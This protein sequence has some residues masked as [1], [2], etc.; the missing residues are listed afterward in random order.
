MNILLNGR[1]KGDCVQQCVGSPVHT[2][3]LA[4]LT[5]GVNDTC[6]KVDFGCKFT[7]GAT[8]TDIDLSKDVTAVNLLPVSSSPVVNSPQVLLTPVVNSEKKH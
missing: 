2:V 7:A 3:L 6:G 1:F 4:L 8:A 5:T